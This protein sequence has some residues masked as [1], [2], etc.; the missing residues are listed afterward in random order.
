MLFMFTSHH[1]NFACKC[2]SLKV[3]WIDDVKLQMSLHAYVCFYQVLT[4]A[5][6][7]R[8]WSHS[9]TWL[10]AE[11]MFVKSDKQQM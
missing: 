9:M 6:S 3:S 5:L 2:G 4:V 1:V 11:I 7:D 8:M 10:I